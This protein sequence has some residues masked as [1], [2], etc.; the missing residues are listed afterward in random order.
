MKKT[1]LVL[2]LLAVGLEA[3][4]A[5]LTGRK[6]I[7]LEIS[8]ARE[9]A[10]VPAAPRSDDS[11]FLR[12]V[13]LDIVGTI[14]TVEE[15]EAFLAWRRTLEVGPTI[16]DLRRRIEALGRAEL[17]RHQGKLAALGPEPRRLVEEIVAGI[18]NKFLHPP[19]VA[20]KH[21][22]QTGFGGLRV[23]LLREIFGLDGHAEPPARQTTGQERASRDTA[24]VTA[25]GGP[26]P[27]EG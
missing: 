1:M 18:T 16:V 10:G 15:T 13:T 25:R 23:R 6:L 11:E 7:D 14:P 5:S 20:L 22:A 26:A 19:T 9:A 12:R 24:E 4:D 8:K 27:G 3:Q 21:A 17:Q 2:A